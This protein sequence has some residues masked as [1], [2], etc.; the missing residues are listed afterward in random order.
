[1]GVGWCRSVPAKAYTIFIVI[2]SLIVIKNIKL[3]NTD[4]TAM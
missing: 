4:R 3:T 1:M 2:V